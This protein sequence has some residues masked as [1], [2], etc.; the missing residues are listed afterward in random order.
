M[1][2]STMTER[3]S[4]ASA[5]S[6]RIRED[7][8]RPLP[9]GTPRGREGVRVSGHLQGASVAVDI[10]LPGKAARIADAITEALT[11]AGYTVTPNPMDALLLNVERNDQ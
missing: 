9:S 2:L 3:R 1:I 5:V 4:F 7:V 8:M 6:R 10:D 11:A